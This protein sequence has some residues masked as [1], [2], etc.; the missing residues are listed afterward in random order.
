MIK[1][2]AFRIGSYGSNNIIVT[3]FLMEYENWQIQ[4]TCMQDPVER[5]LPTSLKNT[6]SKNPFLQ[7]SLDWYWSLK[8]IKSENIPPDLKSATTSPCVRRVLRYLSH[9]EFAVNRDRTRNLSVANRTPYSQS[10]SACSII[11]YQVGTVWLS[12]IFCSK[13]YRAMRRMRCYVLHTAFAV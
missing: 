12:I 8:V 5:T 4:L 10:R 11:S 13:I 1:Q 6:S 2:L 3:G 9:Q 7:L